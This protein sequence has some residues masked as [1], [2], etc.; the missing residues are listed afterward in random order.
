MSIKKK[1]RKMKTSRYLTVQ[2]SQN[3]T[4][5]VGTS[6]SRKVGSGMISMFP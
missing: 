6:S 3:V 4:D 5:A 1:S 2:D